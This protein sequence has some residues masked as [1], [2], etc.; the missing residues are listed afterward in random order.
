MTPAS[1]RKYLAIF[2][3][4]FVAACSLEGAIDAMTSEEDRA[5]ALE[6]VDN[7]RHRDAEALRAVV[8]PQL[9]AQSAGQFEQAAALYPAEEGETRFIGYSVHMDSMDDGARTEKEFTL[10]TTDERH[11]TTTRFSTVQAGGAPVVVAWNVEGSDQPPQELE[12][13]ETVGTVF[14]WMGIIGLVVV[15]GLVVLVVWLVRR[16]NRKRRDAGVS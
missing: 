7:I 1:I 6:F 8:D 9:W 16:S 14:M 2:A 12:A 13:M 11:W 5:M 10:V 15:I 4:L 3:M